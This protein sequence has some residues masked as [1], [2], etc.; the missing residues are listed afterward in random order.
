LKFKA[1]S[2]L[3]TCLGLSVK[4]IL[5]EI[6]VSFYLMLVTR[7]RRSK[8]LLLPESGDVLGDISLRIISPSRS[9]A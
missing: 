7:R 6:K 4:I 1:G 2:F 8:E 3:V 9:D 5:C